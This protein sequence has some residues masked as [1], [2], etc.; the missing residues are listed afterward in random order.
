MNLALPYC[1]R[2]ALGEDATEAAPSQEP[3]CRN[4]WVC[5]YTDVYLAWRPSVMK[6]SPVA[7]HL[8]RP[9]SRVPLCLDSGPL[10]SRGARLKVE[11]LETLHSPL[12]L[13]ASTGSRGPSCAWV[14]SVQV[15][16][17]QGEVGHPGSWLGW[18]G[19]EG[20]CQDGMLKQSGPSLNSTETASNGALQ[21]GDWFP[22]RPEEHFHHST[23]AKYQGF[24]AGPSDVVCPFCPHFT[25]PYTHLGVLG[26]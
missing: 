7:E 4:C 14:A 19:N 13:A 20:S 3:V 2:E 15:H 25:G 17:W 26:E 10:W 16:G 9:L 21:R 18:D 1:L 12:S 6:P 24:R 5:S 11:P 23:T 22:C 8:G